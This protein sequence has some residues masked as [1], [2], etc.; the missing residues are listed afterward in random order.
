M[1][2]SCASR[3]A[4]SHPPQDRSF[5]LPIRINLVR[6]HII[7]FVH[8]LCVFFFVLFSPLSCLICIPP[9]PANS[10]NAG[11]VCTVTLSYSRPT[12]I[13]SPF[14]VIVKSLLLLFLLVAS[15]ALL[16]LC[17]RSICTRA[18]LWFLFS[19]AL[20]SSR[21]AFSS[22]ACSFSR[23]FRR[24]SWIVS[25]REREST[26]LRERIRKPL[27]MLVLM[28]DAGDIV[29]VS[30]GEVRS[31]VCRLR[32]VC[33]VARA[34]REEDDCLVWTRKG[35][36]RELETTGLEVVFA[37]AVKDGLRWF[38]RFEAERKACRTLVGSSSSV[39][40][41]ELE[42][43]LSRSEFWYEAASGGV[44]GRGVCWNGCTKLPVRCPLPVVAI[45]N[46]DVPLVLRLWYPLRTIPMPV[47][48]LMSCEERDPVP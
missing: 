25:D 17:P 7:N 3:C 44:Y 18:S 38:D 20:I 41:G 21:A 34:R 11:G 23:N 31:C 16:L 37:P 19:R 6:N 45:E 10:P 40:T 43:S 39:T 35:W 22:L 9:S 1:H 28:A 13:L 27:S 2:C 15:L 8:A 32:F 36:A 5:F 47:V 26:S 29:G 12:R 30:A 33:E 48:K 24:A 4:C 14:S 42:C 46:C